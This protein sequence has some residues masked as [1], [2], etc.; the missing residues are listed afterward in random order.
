M[1]QIRAEVREKSK[2]KRAE[3][4]DYL[5]SIIHSLFIND[6]YLKRSEKNLKEIKK[7]EKGT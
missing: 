3:I 5:F 2:D 6:D 4:S 7:G 1:Q